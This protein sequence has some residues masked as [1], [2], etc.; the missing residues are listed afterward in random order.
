MLIAFVR[1]CVRVCWCARACVLTKLCIKL[2]TW[3]LNFYTPKLSD[4]LKF[5]HSMR[6]REKHHIHNSIKAMIRYI[7]F[8][9]ICL[10]RAKTHHAMALTCVEG[11]L[12]LLLPSM[13]RFNQTEPATFL[14]LLCSAFFLCILGFLLLSFRH[15]STLVQQCIRFQIVCGYLI[16]SIV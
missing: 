9:R 3:L 12:H 4:I 11:S 16:N 1:A 2:Q 15:K 5:C 7:T 10:G 14:V 8:S 13:N 6:K